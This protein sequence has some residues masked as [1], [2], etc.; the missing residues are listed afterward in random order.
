MIFFL[1][2]C[3]V[4]SINIHQYSSTSLML[5]A[6]LSNL[7]TSLQ[8]CARFLWLLFLFK[9]SSW[10]FLVLA[11]G[12]DIES[13]ELTVYPFQQIRTTSMEVKV[14]ISRHQ[15]RAPYRR[16]GDVE[17]VALLEILQRCKGQRSHS[18]SKLVPP[19][20]GNNRIN[21]MK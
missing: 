14:D 9:R 15:E 8:S 1:Q 19:Q 10:I 2:D 4:T 7:V 20:T 6:F 11:A 18:T 17:R 13:P 16:H 21:T 3:W 12:G 5:R